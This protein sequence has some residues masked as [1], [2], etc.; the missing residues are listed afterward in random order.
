MSLGPNNVRLLLYTKPFPNGVAR[1]TN[2]IYRPYN[3]NSVSWFFISPLTCFFYAFETIWYFLI[4][5]K[6]DVSII[7]KNLTS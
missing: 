7:Q 1:V 2:I 5:L 3:C 6:R 4:D